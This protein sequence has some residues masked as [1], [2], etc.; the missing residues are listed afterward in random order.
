MSKAAKLPEK[1]R[2]P[3]IAMSQGGKQLLLTAMPADLLVKITYVAVRRQDEEDGAVQ[4]PLN[5]RR[6]SGI[7]DFALN[8]GDFPACIILNWVNKENLATTSKELT[9]TFAKKSAQIIDGQHRVAGLEQA[10][11]EKRSIGRMQ[12]PVAIYQQLT[13]QQCADI[14]LSI[15]TEQKPV[16]KSL[17]YDLFGIA[18]EHVI[19]AAAL[20]AADLADVLNK[21]QD[22][23]YFE[24]VKYLGDKRAG[25]T[26][27]SIGIALSTIVN[28]LK[29][30]V[31]EK[32][33]FETSGVRDFEKQSK[34]VLN[35]FTVLQEWYGEEWLDRNNA[36]MHAAGFTGAIEFLKTKLIPYCNVRRS[37]SL[38]TIRNAM[39]LNQNRRLRREDLA[40]MQG[41]ASAHKVMER[42]LEQFDPELKQEKELEF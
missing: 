14:F 33:V 1:F 38:E 34:V 40:K 19:D 31:A 5:D 22:S 12:I 7:R 36:F 17:A 6:I 32:G 37:Y 9:I 11:L 27:P 25:H 15:N 29:P 30:L 13:T 16:A 20:R 3:F 39:K 8:G 28:A 10:I 2:L 35:Y 24:L 42:L 21:D 41:R 4:R 23:P 18:S 26:K